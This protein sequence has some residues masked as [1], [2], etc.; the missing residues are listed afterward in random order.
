MEIS[1]KSIVSVDSFLSLIKSILVSPSKP[2]LL[3]HHDA[4]YSTF[5]IQ[6]SALLLVML[7]P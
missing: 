6:V 3:S 7:H 5:F 4:K 1:T 2:L